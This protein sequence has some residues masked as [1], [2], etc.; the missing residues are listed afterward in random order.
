MVINPQSVISIYENIPW[1]SDMK[2]VRLFDSEVQQT[3]YMNYHRKYRV[4][5]CTYVRDE[6]V[7]RVP[8]AADNLFGCN[9]L[10]F[11]N[12]GFGNK[13]FYAFI[14]DVKYLNNETSEISFEIDMFQTW[15]FNVDVGKCFVER[16]H[17]NDDTIG[18]NTVAEDVDTGDLCVHT[19]WA[20]YWAN[21]DD[22]GNPLWKVV[23]QV[24]PSIFMN[25]E[26]GNYEAIYYGQNQFYPCTYESDANHV[27]DLQNWIPLVTA[28][29]GQLTNTYMCPKEFSG[30][31]PIPLEDLSAKGIHRPTGFLN[32]YDNAVLPSEYVPHNNKLLT[33]PYTK[34]IVA[35]TDGNHEEY[36]WERTR[37]GVVE[38]SLY[39]NQL[40]KP[41]CELRPTNYF[42]NAS[43]RMNVVHIDE[44]P[45]VTMSQFESLNLGN[46]YNVVS[47]F[48]NQLS[49]SPAS[50][51]ANLGS[52]VA[53]I[54]TDNG[55]HTVG[56]S[57]GCLDLKYQSFGFIFY[58]M[59]IDG[60]HARVID[61]YFTRYGYQINE[62]KQPELRG[63]RYY[64]YIKTRDCMITPR[65]DYY[66]PNEALT[67]IGD[68]FNSGITLWHVDE[69]F[70]LYDENPILVG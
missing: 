41:S 17:V 40:N 62:I 38:F 54:V 46:L 28:V 25:L 39:Y 12:R 26:G 13:T 9:Y 70:G 33:S 19:V 11:T 16:E 7:I 53:S 61:D 51:M 42:R 34:L 4:D 59:A 30:L 67:S 64:N 27:Q 2:N 18:A 29:G 57:D 31:A 66:A 15:W 47:S 6:R 24:K 56:T 21:S 68:M 58:V 32:Y 36:Q 63:R 43:Q 44:F 60:N 35:S 52:G 22:Q 37:Y 5:G 20:R 14:T 45:K 48:A 50:A 10:S 8:I 3:N 49:N 1:K 69:M 65:G 55:N 23:V